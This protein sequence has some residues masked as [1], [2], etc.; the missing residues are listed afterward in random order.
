M[1]LSAALF[2]I[3]I[4]ANKNNII[5]LALQIGEPVL[6]HGGRGVVQLLVAEQFDAAVREVASDHNLRLERGQAVLDRL[7]IRQGRAEG[8][9]LLHKGA[10][11]LETCFR[12]GDGHV[13]DQ[14]A[15]L[16]QLVHQV[17]ETL[18]FLSKHGAGGHA[19]VLEEQLT[20]VLRF[21]A[22]LLE[23]VALH[24]ALGA[25]V[26]EEEGDPLSSLGWVGLGADDDQVAVPAVGDVRLAAVD[27]VVV[28]VT[29]GGGA[30]ACQVRSGLHIRQNNS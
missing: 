30:H 1:Q 25:L 21:H 14:E 15:L 10:R 26:H 16:R 28:S 24:E 19:A 27:D 2:D 12:R 7:Q 22:E 18:V 3:N 8:L 23:F 11:P 29:D 17:D 5:Y 4:L 6:S 20:G 13:S 9:S